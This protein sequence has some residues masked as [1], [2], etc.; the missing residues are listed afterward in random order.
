MRNEKYGASSFEHFHLISGSD[1]AKLSDL[2]TQ[3]E[4]KNTLT[5]ETYY[6]FH[7]DGFELIAYMETES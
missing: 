1:L 5:S 2:V 6:F 7:Q 4:C 3:M